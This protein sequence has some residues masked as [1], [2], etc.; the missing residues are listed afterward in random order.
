MN[1]D[2]RRGFVGGENKAVGGVLCV[3]WSPLFFIGLVNTTRDARVFVA[4]V[5]CCGGR[6]VKVSTS[7]SGCGLLFVNSCDCVV[8]CCVVSIEG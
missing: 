6:G 5:H 8:D 1:N 7:G 4:P 3:D 2:V